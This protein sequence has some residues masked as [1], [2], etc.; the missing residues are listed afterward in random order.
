M[1]DQAHVQH[2]LERMEQE[3]YLP[4]PG[5]ARCGRVPIK[6][7]HAARAVH[8]QCVRRSWSQVCIL[9]RAWDDQ[10]A[11][12]DDVRPVASVDIAGDFSQAFY[13]NEDELETPEKLDEEAAA[14]ARID[15][16][17]NSATRGAHCDYCGDWCAHGEYDEDW[18]G[19]GLNVCYAGEHEAEKAETEA[20][21]LACI[22]RASHIAT[23][24]IL[25]RGIWR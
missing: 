11:L 1:A 13:I 3:E 5:S 21:L 9:V 25:P 14:E 23:N 22:G 10:C 16:L 4:V 15:D 6:G 7:R 17:L 12:A 24:P 2:G 8:S 19:T 18:M 20:L